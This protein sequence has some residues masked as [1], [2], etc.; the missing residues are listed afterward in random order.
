[1]GMYKEKNMTKDKETFHGR[2]SLFYYIFIFQ[3]NKSKNKKKIRKFF[4]V[5]LFCMGYYFMKTHETT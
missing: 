3:K 4:A 2:K 1:M 5:F